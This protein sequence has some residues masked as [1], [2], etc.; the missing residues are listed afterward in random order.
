M[1]FKNLKVTQNGDESAKKK[2]KKKKQKTENGDSDW[3]PSGRQFFPN[4]DFFSTRNKLFLLSLGYIIDVILVLTSKV[5]GVRFLNII[6]TK[7]ICA[8]K[9]WIKIAKCS[10]VT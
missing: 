8:I 5:I 10:N 2:K 7:R 9:L 1:F 4:P 3:N 6:Y